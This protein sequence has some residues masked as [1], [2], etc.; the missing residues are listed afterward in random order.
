VTSLLTRPLR[1]IAVL[2]ALGAVA[3][4]YW[5]WHGVGSS[6]AADRIDAVAEFRAKGVPETAP[7]PGVPA[8]GVYRFRTVGTE[9]A[10]SGVL[11]ASRPL[12]DE[13][14]YIISPIA[15]GYHEDLRI[16]QEHVEEA[17]FRVSEAG[18]SA[19]WRRT[20][21]TF[22]GIG[23]DDRSD[24]TPAALDHPATLPVGRAWKGS[25]A[26]GDIDVTYRG[27]VVAAER[28]RL[29]GVSVPVVV[30]RTDAT[31]TGSTTGTRTDVVRWAPSLNLPVTWSI[32][33]ETGGEADY[34]I[35]ADLELV[36]AT[37]AR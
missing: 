8:S 30:I 32:D 3:G 7:A 13:A 33:Q 17:R 25:Y 21:I 28:A 15:G 19:T 37:P 4:A 16:S 26:L 31:F 34:S 36:S 10:G 1:L 14:V 9:S 27:R 22:L 18:T 24:V 12:P 11:S 35:S 20:K 6:T 5:V 2:A 23:E 29:D